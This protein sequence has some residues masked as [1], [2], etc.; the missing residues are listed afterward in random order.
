MLSNYISEFFTSMKINFKSFYLK[1]TPFMVE[2]ITC[3]LFINCE[4][5][6][7]FTINKI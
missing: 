6:Y 3:D 5:G 7:V 2:K 4:Y 1:N